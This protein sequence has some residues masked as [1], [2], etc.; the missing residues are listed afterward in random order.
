MMVLEEEDKPS[1]RAY[2][3]RKHIKIYFLNLFH[4]ESEGGKRKEISEKTLRFAV[5]LGPFLPR[6]GAFHL[7]SDALQRVNIAFERGTSYRAP[8]TSTR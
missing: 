3:A 8:K 5:T 6:S 7:R 2:A 1:A 4:V